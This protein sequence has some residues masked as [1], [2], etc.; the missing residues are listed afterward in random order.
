MQRASEIRK[1]KI[2]ILFAGKGR[3]LFDK[4]GCCAASKDKLHKQHIADRTACDRQKHLS[5]PQVKP[6]DNKNSGCL[7]YTVTAGQDAD[8]FQA[9]DYQH[10]EDGSGEGIA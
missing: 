9:V 4:F 6:H 1:L 3:G 10:A 7:R 8:I 5:F 2:R